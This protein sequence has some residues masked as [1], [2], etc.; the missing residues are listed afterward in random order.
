VPTST[1]KRIYRLA[2]ICGLLAVI[3]VVIPRFVRNPEGGF[4]SGTSAV[5]VF[6]MLL[7][8]TAL[9]SVYLLVV[10]VRSYRSLTI[11]PRLVGIAPG[12]LFVGALVLLLG[13]LRY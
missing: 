3:A 13:F 7:L 2:S 10:T 8:V 9:V 1:E 11:A 5:L 4:A 6:M 12:V